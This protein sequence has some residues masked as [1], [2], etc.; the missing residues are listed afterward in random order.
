MNTLGPLPLHVTDPLDS[1]P[2]TVG[3]AANAAQAA[4]AGRDFEEMFLTQMLAPMFEGLRTE[5]AFGGGFG[6]KMFR[7]LQVTEYARAIVQS[8]GIGI[9]NAVARELITLQEKAHG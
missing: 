9:A 8:G 3:K 2:I 7:S 4:K 1:K 6:E 5:G